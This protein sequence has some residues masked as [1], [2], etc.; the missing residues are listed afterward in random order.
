MN[1]QYRQPRVFDGHPQAARVVTLIPV[2][3]RIEELRRDRALI[4]RAIAALTEVSRRRDI[5]RRQGRQELI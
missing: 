2:D 4:E 3:E 1:S 5:R